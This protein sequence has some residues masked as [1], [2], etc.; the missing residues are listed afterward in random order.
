[1]NKPLRRNTTSIGLVLQAG[2]DTLNAVIQR[3]F[4]SSSLIPIFTIEAVLLLLYFGISSYISAKNQD[5]LEAEARYTLEHTASDKT[6]EIDLQLKEISNYARLLQGEHQRYFA[7]PSRVPLPQSSIRFEVAPNGIFYKVE[8]TTGGSLYYSTVTKIGEAERDKALR[9]EALDPLFQFVVD[10]NPN[11]VAVYLN[12]FDS[13]N[14][15][16]PFITDVP[17]QY[18]PDMNIPEF[19]FYYLADAAH[20]PKRDVVWTGVYLDPAGQGWM[21]SCIV[22]VYR[23]DFLEGVTGLDVTIEKFVNNILAF[24]LRWGASAFLADDDGLIL[25]MSKEVEKTLGLK[26]LG[27]HVYEGSVTQDTNKPEDFNLLKSGR[28]E[29][30]EQFRTFF[31]ENIAIGEFGSGSKDYLLSQA[32]VPETGWR[33]F[34]I[35]DKEVLFRP[36]EEIKALSRHIGY[37]AVA[38]MLI[39]Y[40]VFFVYLVR[41]AQHLSARLSPPIES[42]SFLTTTFLTENRFEKLAAVG[43]REIDALS[44][45]FHEMVVELRAH[46]DLLQ[47]TNT[48]LEEELT[49]R[50]ATEKELARH[51]DNLEEMVH[52]RTEELHTVNRSLELEI[53]ERRQAE[54]EIRK[55]K[56]VAD[57]ALYGV[58]LLSTEGEVLYVNEF[59]A[60]LVGV[61][62]SDLLG[63]GVLS[64]LRRPSSPTLEDVW[65]TLQEHRSLKALELT[66]PGNGPFPRTLFLNGSAIWGD[67]GGVEFYGLMVLDIT[68]PKRLERELRRS[69]K[70][71]SMGQLAAGIAHE[72]NTPIQYVGDSIHFLK[73]S[74]EDTSKLMGRYR[75]LIL[76]AN[77]GR[78]WA[79][80][81]NDIAEAEEEADVEYTRIH[82][83]ESFQRAYD[84]LARVARIVSAMKEFAHPDSQDMVLTD[85]NHALETTLTV[86]RGEIKNVAEVETDFQ[87][88]PFIPAFLGDLNQVFIN[89][90]VNA[91]DAIREKKEK[92]DSASQ[93]KIRLSTKLEGD[94]VHIAISDNGCGIDPEIMDRIFDQFF[95]TKDVGK[96]TGQGLAISWNIIVD[97][98]RGRIEA[99]SRVGE[100]TTFHIRLPIRV[101]PQK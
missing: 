14:R 65:Q 68:E 81:E 79:D 53:Q 48:R 45:N 42:L 64:L 31:K 71:E 2:N 7:D 43:V 86:A 35:V 77:K 76:E 32:R 66:L 56:T 55:F 85:I 25:A 13:M 90:I 30:A 26:E 40:V 52:E 101:E 96:G 57:K 75:E 80:L 23:G 83:P 47:Q 95:T 3:N 46:T 22:P 33:L 10:K 18:A 59:L 15:Y 16:I 72:I 17:G 98:H 67:S 91:A 62:A 8:P 97:K 89:L 9:T 24:K 63:N 51:R 78:S 34:L 44:D 19:N 61:P 70:L 36:I 11:V 60:G 27:K 37:A 41:K 6:Q 84:G 58:A 100:G 99:E 88:I 49:I 39:F 38:V 92:E 29:T 4:L 82:V 50:K 74:C 69:Q 94:W 93:G 28:P 87:P 73:E 54:R 21:A 5:L 1:M 20:N 12:T